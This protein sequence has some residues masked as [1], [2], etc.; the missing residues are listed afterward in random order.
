MG[1]TKIKKDI[2][3]FNLIFTIINLVLLVE[4]L[5]WMNT[6]FVT[7]AEDPATKDAHETTATESYAAGSLRFV[8]AL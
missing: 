4:S 5:V 7:P 8:C 2:L 1:D 6:C 3:I